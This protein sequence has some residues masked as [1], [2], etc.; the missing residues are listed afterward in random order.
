M[1]E[2]LR[3]NFNGHTL[4]ILVR[5]IL[6][7][8]EFVGWRT[9]LEWESRKWKGSK[10]SSPTA[11]KP[12]AMGR[13][14]LSHWRIRTRFPARRFALKAERHSL[15]IYCRSDRRADFCDIR[16]SNNRNAKTDSSNWFAIH[17]EKNRG[18]G[19]R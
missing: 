18:V 13:V 3:S 14:S 7:N 12:T 2:L 6:N 15:A 9:P 19:W 8:E 5:D 10:G 16:V 1:V 4:F 11:S 17:D